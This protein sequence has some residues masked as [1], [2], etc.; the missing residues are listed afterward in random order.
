[1]GLFKVALGCACMPDQPRAVDKGALG[2]P[3]DAS[4]LCLQ[5]LVLVLS[6]VLPGVRQLLSSAGMGAG[7]PMRA[8]VML[9][10]A[11]SAVAANCA[12][13]IRR[14]CSGR[15]QDSPRSR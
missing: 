11:S 2:R 6:S 1:V 12:H 15:R 4:R 14:I 5:P 3:H 9:L 8:R 7:R 13:R 10:T